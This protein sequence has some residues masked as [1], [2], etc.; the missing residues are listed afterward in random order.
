M[1]FGITCG[2][3]LIG[4]LVIGTYR[5]CVCLIVWV[6]LLVECLLVL[7][8]YDNGIRLVWVCLFVEV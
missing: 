8:A 4:W 5:V 7:C 2:C 3:V 1:V 6:G